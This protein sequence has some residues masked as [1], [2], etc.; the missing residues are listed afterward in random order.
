MNKHLI[1]INGTMG[2]GKTAVCRELYKE[3]ENSVWLDGDWCWLMHPWDFSEENRKMAMNN[4]Q[5]LLKSYLLNST[6]RYIFF[7]WV[8]HRAEI[9]DEILN[10]LKDI[11]YIL[12]KITIT[13][14]ED[15]LRKR[16]VKENRDEAS[17]RESIKRLVNY[18][19]M[20]TIKI[21][22][23]KHSIKETVTIIA[24]ILKS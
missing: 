2:A 14:S 18:E 4:I 8:M 11:T 12:H 15:E 7:S 17:I 16:M 22:T 1:M 21:D 20:D 6:L 5:F 24:G 13:C 19:Q 23:T 10:S 3:F 9:I